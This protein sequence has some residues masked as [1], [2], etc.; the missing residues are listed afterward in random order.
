MTQVG[1]K[2]VLFAAL[3]PALCVG[4][5]RNTTP[6]ADEVRERIA[7]LLGVPPSTILGAGPH[8]PPGIVG[9]RIWTLANAVPSQAGTTVT[10][11]H[12]RIAFYGTPSTNGHYL[13]PPGWTAVSD[14]HLSVEDAR[15]Q[16][17]QLATLYWMQDAPSGARLTVT[18][19]ELNPHGSDLYVVD[20][21]LG[22]AGR[23]APREATL[24]VDVRGRGCPLLYTKDWP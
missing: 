19:A 7:P 6:A 24:Y 20:I 12:G 21:A 13:R 11:Y 4:C 15:V 9:D 23:Y 14:A 16:A 17:C 10:T 22:S 18:R 2:A 5:L 8:P 3:L 1:A